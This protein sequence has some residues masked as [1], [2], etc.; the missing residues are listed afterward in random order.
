M[1]VRLMR[2]PCGSTSGMELTRALGIRALRREGT[3]YRPRFGDVILNW[4]CTQ[5][6][7]PS[8]AE[9]RVRWIND[10][11][12]VR[13]AVH[14]EWAW[15]QWAHEGIPTV[16]WTDDWWTAHEWMRNGDRILA[17]ST[18]RG[19][20]GRGITVHS[21][22]GTKYTEAG[23]PESHVYVKAFGYNPAKVTEYRVHVIGGE[24]VDVVQKKR[25]R[26][27][28][29][30]FNPYIRNKRYGWVFCREEVTCPESVIESGRRAVNSLGLDF[31]AADTAVSERGDACVY[32]VNTAPGLEGTT[33]VE[34]RDA[35]RRMI[36]AE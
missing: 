2:P 16:E 30:E 7:F 34:Y 36:Y 32:E 10:P 4:G 11:L 26:E 33:L 35:L 9:F 19:S 12:K 21:L 29:G 13:R 25:R 27:H 23:L 22:E 1:R 6:Q 8:D 15:N 14:K 20:Q 24:V 17:R 28:E 31:G 5:Q 18:L 3:R